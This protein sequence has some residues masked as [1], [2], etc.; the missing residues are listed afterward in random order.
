M[1]KGDVLESKPVQAHPASAHYAP[2]FS[3][4]ATVVV[5]LLAVWLAVAAWD[6]YQTTP[7]TRDARVRAFTVVVAPQV[8]GQVTKIDVHDNQEVKAGQVLMRI[9]PADFQNALAVAQA[10]LASDEAVEAM[11]MANARRR[12]QAPLSAVSAENREDTAS[13]ATAAAAAVMADKAHVAQAELNLARSVVYAPVNGVVTN[14]S[15]HVGDYAHTGEGMISVVD[16][17]DIW[18]TGYFEETE[19][20]KIKPGDKVRIKLMAYP[21]EIIDGHVQGIGRGIAIP[22][23]ENGPSGLP[24]VDPIYAWVRLTQ[25]LPVHITLDHVPSDIQLSAGMTANAQIVEPDSNK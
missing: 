25:R 12:A 11:K 5:V 10:Q 8:S 22:D 24:D 16:T 9:D 13:E 23:A 18:V 20:R 17:Q 19:L 14:L 2:I 21:N 4:V 15:A 7:W 1:S 6:Y 3:V